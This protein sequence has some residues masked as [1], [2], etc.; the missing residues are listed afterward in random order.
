[1]KYAPINFELKDGR[2]CKIREIQ[3]K[4]A[5]ETIEYLK[6]VMGESDFLYSYPEEITMSAEEEEKALMN[7]I[8]HLCLLS[9]WMED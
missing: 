8:I 4:D 3:V 6:T 5:A 1:M 9:K 7:L 2:I